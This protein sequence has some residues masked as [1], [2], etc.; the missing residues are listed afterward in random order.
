MCALCQSFPC[1]P[2]CPNAPDP[3]PV[4]RCAECGEGIY[5]GDDYYDIGNGEGICKGCIDEK[6]TSEL[7]ELFGESFSVAS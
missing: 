7:M 4:M 5:P 3:V 1:H 2:R 6:S